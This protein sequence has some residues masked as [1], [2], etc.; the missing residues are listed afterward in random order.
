MSTIRRHGVAFHVIPTPGEG[1]WLEVIRESDGAVLISER[2]RGESSDELAPAVDEWFADIVSE[3]VDAFEVQVCRVCGARRRP[4][5]DDCGIPLDDH[6]VEW[7]FDLCVACASH[8]EQTNPWMRTY[9][10]DQR[11]PDLADDW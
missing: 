3:S 7:E 8:L 10:R 1:L 11:F 4:V 6:L 2:F 5:E 9:V